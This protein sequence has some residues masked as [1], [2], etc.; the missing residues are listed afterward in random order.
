MVMEPPPA[1]AFEMIE[2]ELVLQLLVIAF[3]APAQMRQPSERGHGRRRGQRRE[4]VLRWCRLVEGPL[5]QEPFGR[6]GLATPTRRRWHDPQRHKARAH[7]AASAFAPRL[8]GP[9]RQRQAADQ[10]RHPHGL[11][12]SEAVPATGS[13]AAAVTALRRLRGNSRRPN[14]GVLADAEY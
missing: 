7:A 10:R 5:T 6:R 14:F 11:L 4:V 12:A 2:P 9:R 13:S 8:R 3:D 1:A